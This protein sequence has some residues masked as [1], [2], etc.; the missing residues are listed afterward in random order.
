M[1]YPSKTQLDPHIVHSKQYAIKC[2]KSEQHPG[3]LFGRSEY[4]LWI[5][6]GRLFLT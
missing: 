3:D 1:E 5:Y 2:N 4:I 6:Y